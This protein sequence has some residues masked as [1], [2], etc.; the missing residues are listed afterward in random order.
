M[1]FHHHAISLALLMAMAS[2]AAQ[3]QPVPD[4]P[5]SFKEARAMI[6]KRFVAADTNHD[7]KLTRE[8]AEAGMPQVYK[9]F[10]EID[11]RKRG[12]VTERQIG[13]YWS[14]VTKAHMQQEDPIWN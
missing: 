12:Y 13:A 6:H 5:G 4:I 10:N 1:K 3:V 14:A 11:A 8:E 2:V 7:G 9:H